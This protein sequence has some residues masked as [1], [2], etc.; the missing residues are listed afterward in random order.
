MK[1]DNQNSTKLNNWK[2]I[3]LKNSAEKITLQKIQ[4]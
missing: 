3:Q 2:K 4:N 1:V